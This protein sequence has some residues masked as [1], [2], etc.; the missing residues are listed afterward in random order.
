[1]L[2]RVHIVKNKMQTYPLCRWKT[3]I[4][5]IS[6]YILPKIHIP[7]KWSEQSMICRATKTFVKKKKQKAAGALTQIHCHS[8]PPTDQVV[9]I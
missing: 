7:T 9:I 4:H 8:G 2:Y 6:V 1:M 5:E 3:L